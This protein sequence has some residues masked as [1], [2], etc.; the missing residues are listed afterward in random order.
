MVSPLRGSALFSWS[1]RGLAL[2]RP[3]LLKFRHYVPS[4]FPW[5]ISQN[6]KWDIRSPTGSCILAQ[7]TA[8]GIGELANCRLK[9][10]CIKVFRTFSL[11]SYA[12]GLQPAMLLPVHTQGVALGSDLKKEPHRGSTTKPR[13]AM[14]T[15][16][17]L[18]GKV[19]HQRCS[20]KSIHPIVQPRWGRMREHIAYPGCAP[21]PWALV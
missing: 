17:S 5:A 21:R 19:V 16:G 8:L 12:A 9:V 3:R 7:G 11:N 20:T 18:S 1:F 14:R 2:L 13:V 10:C 4:G 15:L 6:M